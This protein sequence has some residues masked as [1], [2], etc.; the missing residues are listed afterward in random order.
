MPALHPGISTAA[1]R[2]ID[3]SSSPCTALDERL[4]GLDSLR[5]IAMFLGVVL[6]GLCS[7]I[8]MPLSPWPVRDLND[9]PGFT[10]LFY[11]LHGCRLHVFFL[12]AGFFGRLLH[13]RMGTGEFVKNR[14]MRVGLPFLCAPVFVLPF[15][16]IALWHELEHP[17]EKMMQRAPGEIGMPTGHAWF[18][19]F[20]LIHYAVALGVTVFARR[21]PEPVLSR[22]DRWFDVMITSPIRIVAL[23]PLT[24]MCLWNGPFWGEPHYAGAGI[25][26][27]LRAVVLYGLFFAVGW[28]LHRRRAVLVELQRFI[29]PSALVALVALASHVAIARTLPAISATNATA[30]KLA[31]LTGTAVYAWGMSFALVGVFLRFGR[32]PSARMRYLADA[33]YWCYLA[34]PPVVIGLQAVMAR[35]PIPAWPKLLLLLGVTMAVLLFTYEHGVR[36]TVIGRVLN[37]PRKRPEKSPVAVAA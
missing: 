6:H 3:G 23:V 14:L 37:G 30:L 21:L 18:L 9:G 12:L 13:E 34:H 16:M 15:L 5:A 8:V 22:L 32:K 27:T 1:E 29:A 31:S 11:L 19:Q 28:W 25:V 33:S 2:P 36:Y 20:L 35:W 4:H 17:P 24:V 10:A 26:P 7:Y